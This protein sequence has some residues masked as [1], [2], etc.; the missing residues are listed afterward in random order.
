MTTLVA[1]RLMTAE[2]FAETIDPPGLT[3]ELVCGKV[4]YMPP[5][6]TNHGYYGTQ[7]GYFLSTFFRPL[8]LGIST[9]EGG[10]ILSRNPDSVRAPDAAF[11]SADRVPADWPE[12]EGYIEGAPSLAVEVVSPRNTRTDIA[13]KV[14]QY[15]AAGSERV[16]EVRPRQRTVTVHRRGAPARTAGVGETLTSDD[17]GF[18]IDGFLLPVADIFA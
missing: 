4:V 14:A 10:Y 15:L 11:L 18:T 3:S 6:K 8:G 2:E 1:E 12:T 16:W 7:V 5:A 13:L 17:A 9:G